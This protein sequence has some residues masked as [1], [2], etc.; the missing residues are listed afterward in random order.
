MF[1]AIVEHNEL[2]AEYRAGGD[3]KKVAA[4]KWQRPVGPASLHRIKESLRAILRPAVDQG[5][6]THNVAKL[7]ELPPAV[8]PKPK[9]WN[10]ERVAKWRRTGQVLYPVMV[11]TADKAGQFL[12]F[13]VNHPLYALCHLIAYTGLRRGEG[14]GQ[15]RSDTYLDAA[16]IEVANQIVQYGW[17][18]GQGRP[19]SL[20]HGARR[21]PSAPR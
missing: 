14:C 4:V 20:L 16:C 8:R 7:V 15:R 11:W 21:Q 18:T 9:L 6:L 19:R 17:E 2:I 10:P 3:P 13:I 5:L 12:G 1:E